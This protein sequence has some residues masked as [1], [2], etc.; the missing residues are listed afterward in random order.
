MMN[1]RDSIS[2]HV[3]RDD[4]TIAMLAIT[5]AS[6]GL[7]LLAGCSP[8]N[9]APSLLDAG[10]TSPT[11]EPRDEGVAVIIEGRA[12]T[13]SEVDEHIKDQFL[14]EFLQQPADRQFEMRETAVRDLVQRRVIEDEAKKQG[15]TSQEL[16]DEIANGVPEPT[17]EEI[18][19]W[20]TENQSRLRGAKLE[21]VAG[22]IKELMLKERRA[23]A[24]SDFLDP[25]LE[26]LS[27]KIVIT[28]PR[29][30]LEATRL[31]RGHADAAVTIMTFSDYQCPYC[32]RSEPVLAEVLE[33]YPDQVR[34][35]HRHFPLDNIHPFARPASEAAMCADEQGRFW[36]YH[37]GIFARRGRLEDGSL[38]EIASDIGLDTD[39]F[40]LCIEER[41][42]KDFV[43]AD[44][45]AGQAAGVTGT[46]SFFLNGIKLKG[47]RNADEL[48]RYVDLELARIEAN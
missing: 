21:D 2:T 38:A 28:P 24:M 27:W 33:R 31:V 6:I 15:K 42:Y 48:S 47:A 9:R 37:D 23:K 43:D 40:S 19:S 10:R 22:S 39:A 44:F 20:H 34:L 1:D 32:V 3:S 11:G 4:T 41:R 36:E 18:T 5:L 12:I 13:I 8:R 26:A 46:P 29:N 45:V 25:K 7:L 35:V 14:E 30:E 17:L 16:L